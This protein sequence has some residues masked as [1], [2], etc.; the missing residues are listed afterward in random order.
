MTHLKV[1]PR[2][3]TSG[4]RRLFRFTVTSKTASCR[5]GAIIRF[6]GH[7]THTSRKGKARIRVDLPHRGR[8]KA[9][10]RPKACAPSHA[11]VHA[12]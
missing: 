7:K 1:T 5:V 8:W 11:F 4:K 12:R 2:R 9:V 6:A 10:V 3:A